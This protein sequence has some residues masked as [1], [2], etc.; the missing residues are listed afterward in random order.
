[1]NTNLGMSRVDRLRAL[2]DRDGHLCFHPEC[3]KPFKNLTAD[4]DIT[5]DNLE[6]FEDITFD[7]WYPRSLGGTWDVENLRMMH[8]RCNALKGDRVPLEDGSIPGPYNQLRAADRRA[9]KRGLRVEVCRKCNSGRDLGP[10]EYCDV[11]GSVAM[12][13]KH[14]NWAKLHPNDCDHKGI[15]W[16]WA[17]MSGIIMR[18]PAIVQVLGGEDLDD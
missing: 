12:P 18:E 9:A 3:R 16:C 7:H 14:P 13:F 4:I 2:R 5:A 6:L 17:C 15:W 1:M 8:K 10:D 11:C